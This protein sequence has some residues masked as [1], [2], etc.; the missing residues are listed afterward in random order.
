[1]AVGLRLVLSEQL[2]A[3]ASRVILVKCP[4]LSCVRKVTS[5]RKQ[6]RKIVQF[7]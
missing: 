5:A 1:M 3:T 2:N 4:L 6:S 7:M